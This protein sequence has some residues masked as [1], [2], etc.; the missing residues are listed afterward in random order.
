M[1]NYQ[2]EKMKRVYVCKI[3]NTYLTRDATEEIPLCCGK[4]MIVMDELSED[5]AYEIK[6]S[7]GG[8]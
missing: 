8:L 5:E 2:K 6:D 1:G 3:C 4:G 7:S